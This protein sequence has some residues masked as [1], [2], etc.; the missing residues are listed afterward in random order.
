MTPNPAR[1]SRL[2]V[3]PP[4]AAPTP[5]LDGFVAVRAATEA[6]A[7]PLSAED[8]TIQ[9][10]P[11]VSPTK[12]HRAHTTWFWEQFVLMP[13][14]PGYVPY[15]E[16]YLYLF[17]SYYE[18]A[19]P[20]HPRAARGLLSRPGVG[21]VTAYRQIVDDAMAALFRSGRAEPVRHIVEIGL[22]HE[23]QHQE[24]LLM[25]IKHV[26]GIN[27]LHPTYSP[28]PAA[29]GPERELG[30]VRHDGGLVEIGADDGG[31]RFIFDNEAP[32]HRVWLA[33]FDL[34]D[35]LVTAG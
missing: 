17:N 29:G 7:A 18:G 24:L 16:R 10:M 31:H 9:S 12:W 2:D 13:Y 11:A 30:W 22:H 35:R 5:D 6:L 23:Q 14:A 33:P 32:R 21:E 25:D 27:L 26:L 1:S 20:R 19:G 4:V 15:D 34:A 3:P 8:Q 28:R